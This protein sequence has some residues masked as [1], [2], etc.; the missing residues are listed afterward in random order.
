MSINIDFA[1]VSGRI[2]SRTTKPTNNPYLCALFIRKF[3]RILK[4]ISKNSLNH[5]VSSAPTA[6]GA[7]L[8][9]VCAY[10]NRLRAIIAQLTPSKYVFRLLWEHRTLV[11]MN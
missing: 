4:I 11:A 3:E 9:M 7:S 8:F 6:V 2:R 10:L 5:F 1:V